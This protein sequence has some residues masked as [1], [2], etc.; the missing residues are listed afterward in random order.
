[1]FEVLSKH[2]FRKTLFS[3]KTPLFSQKTPLFSKK[4]HCF[5]TCALFYPIVLKRKIITGV[6]CPVLQMKYK[7]PPF[8]K[9]CLSF[10]GFSHD[11]QNHMEEITIE[12]GNIPVLSVVRS[13]DQVDMSSGLQI[14]VLNSA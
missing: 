10:L 12:N 7:V 14:N 5:P 8:H 2:C 1:M 9:K 6:M 11:E 4:N 3:Q 13:H